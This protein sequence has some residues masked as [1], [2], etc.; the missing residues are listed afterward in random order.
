MLNNSKIDLFR[1]VSALFTDYDGT[2][3]PIDV[4]R[5][6][7]KPPVAIYE[8]LNEISKYIPIAVISTKDCDF[9]IPRTDFARAWSCTNGLEIRIGGSHH[10]HED[11]PKWQDKFESLI[12]AINSIN[13]LKGIYLEVKRVG[14]LIGGLGIDWRTK[15]SINMKVLNQII[16]S[17]SES[18]FKVIK[19]R[20][21]PF[22]DIYPGIQ[23]D[24]GY[25]VM[26]LRELM[27]IKGSIMY[28]GDSENDIPAMRIVEY[29]IG[30][31][32]RYNEGLDLPVL[33]WVHENELPIFLDYL[34]TAL[35]SKVH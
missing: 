24:K 15:G 30:I 7:S 21:H 25:A 19:Y 9:L 17:A 1:N 18:G 35:K 6:L 14:N 8:K 3:A 33:L 26:R 34:L 31:R 12:N 29:P 2:I 28:M 32:H 20:G 13:E 10:I 16:K 22:I 5:Q 11:L 4:A 27:G 23:I